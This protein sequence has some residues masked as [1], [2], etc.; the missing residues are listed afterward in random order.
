MNKQTT[1]LILAKDIMRTNLVV[2]Q[3]NDSLA[4]AIKCFVKHDILVVPVVDKMGELVGVA[5]LIELYRACV[6]EH[7]IWLEDLSNMLNFENFHSVIENQN[8]IWL[9]EII[10]KENA[11]VNVDTHA[12]YIIQQ[13]IKN[14]SNQAYVL[15]GKKL[16]GIVTTRDL[17]QAIFG[18]NNH[19]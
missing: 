11:V 13:I 4:A 2:L 3:E 16:V 14:K 7:I 1:N 12:M 10:V 19:E 18:D 15:D 9:N 8:N 5:S 17:A 6:P